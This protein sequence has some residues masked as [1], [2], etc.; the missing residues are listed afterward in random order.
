MEWKLTSAVLNKLLGAIKHGVIQVIQQNNTLD[1]ILQDLEAT[2]LESPTS[3]II[4]SMCTAAALISKDYLIADVWKEAETN[5]LA[6]S[7]ELSKVK[8][9]LLEN[10]TFNLSRELGVLQVLSQARVHLGVALSLVLYPSS[11]DPVTM[12]VAEY[13]FHSQLVSLLL[14]SS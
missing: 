7:N 13:L 1:T 6:A 2:S 9:Q 8:S 14:Y 3:Q 5:L 10:V 12:A 11:V 4:S